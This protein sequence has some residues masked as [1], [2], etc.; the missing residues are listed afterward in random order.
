MIA[1]RLLPMMGTLDA[2]RTRKWKF[3]S[4]LASLQQ[5]TITMTLPWHCSPLTGCGLS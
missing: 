5:P 2:Y 1:Q 4:K 3:C